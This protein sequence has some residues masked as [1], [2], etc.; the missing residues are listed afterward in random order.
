MTAPSIASTIGQASVS[1]WLTGA[2]A[3]WQLRS[4]E[5]LWTA[6]L[7]AG[8]LAAWQRTQGSTNVRG[9][10]AS[11]AAGIAAV[12]FVE[13]GGFCGL[14]TQ[15]VRLGIDGMLG[16]ALPEISIAFAGQQ[17]ATWGLPVGSAS[18]LLQIDVL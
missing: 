8:A 12:P 17:V 13:A 1:T 3:S 14:G 2:S 10:E 9:F 5:G 15:R 18:L 7:G 4:P 16:L 6:T 11:S